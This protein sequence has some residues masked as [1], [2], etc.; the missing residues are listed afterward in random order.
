MAHPGVGPSTAED[1]GEASVRAAF[2]RVM[3]DPRHAP[4]TLATFGVG[5]LGHEAARQMQE[6]RTAHPDW[7][8]PQ[9][10]TEVLRRGTRTAVSRGA[11]I[12]GP[13]LALAPYG[14]CAALLAQN[15]I[16]LELA[17]LAGRDPNAPDR[18]A[19]LLV[20]QDAYPDLDAAR[21]GLAEARSAGPPA[22]PVGRIRAL[23]RVTW[24]LAYLLGFTSRRQEGER[25]VPLWLR[26]L[27]YL[28]MGITFVIGLVAPMV[29]MPYMA[30]SYRQSTARIT[31]RAERFYFGGTTAVR[32]SPTTRRAAWPWPR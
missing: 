29:W 32:H 17:T 26:L 4:E 1:I 5:R 21:A 15:R 25:K 12:G 20:F 13:L 2:G 18:A 16:V 10:R 9:A 7:D 22:Q 27:R 31:Q 8:L 19:E 24:R 11:L 28:L 23:W 6:L 14:F 3:H 30:D